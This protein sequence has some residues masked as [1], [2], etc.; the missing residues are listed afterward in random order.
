MSSF[1]RFYLWGMTAKLYMGI[2]FAAIVF[3]TGLI[4]ALYGGTSLRLVV[5]LEMFV[6]SGLGRFALYV[7]VL[8]VQSAS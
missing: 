4:T 1:K 2:Y 7:N 5:L 3:V 8:L 6:L